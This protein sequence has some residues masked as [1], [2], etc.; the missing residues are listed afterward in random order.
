MTG[1]HEAEGS[2]PFSSTNNLQVFHNFLPPALSS[3]VARSLIDSFSLTTLLQ[4][5]SNL[6][7]AFDAR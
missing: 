2:T 3:A 5:T 4:W 7:P 6:T 1:S